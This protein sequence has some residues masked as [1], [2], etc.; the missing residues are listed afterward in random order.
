MFAPFTRSMTFTLGLFSLA[1]SPDLL[2]A[3]D[4]DTALELSA[5]TISADDLG[6]TTEH[7]GAYTTG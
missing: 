1:L 7:T 4:P 5:T 3:T 2:A 6:A